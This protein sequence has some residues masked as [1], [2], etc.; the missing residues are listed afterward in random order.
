MNSLQCPS[1]LLF[2]VDFFVSSACKT[3]R[4]AA[5]LQE[6]WHASR[7][8]MWPSLTAI[9]MLVEQ[10]TNKNHASASIYVSQFVNTYLQTHDLPSKLG[11][12]HTHTPKK[13]EITLQS[14]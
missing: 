9:W 3:L 5:W 10:P 13:T 2:V 11:H 6:V 7:I 4:V 8:I 1:V 12:I 14:R